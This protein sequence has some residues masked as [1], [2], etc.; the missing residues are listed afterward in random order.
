MGLSTVFDETVLLEMKVEETS[1][2]SIV[3]SCSDAAV[4][5]KQFQQIVKFCV[6]VFYYVSIQFY[7]P[8]D[9]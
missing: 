2:K 9:S 6:C 7:L 1:K 5:P 3:A 4:D 8:Q